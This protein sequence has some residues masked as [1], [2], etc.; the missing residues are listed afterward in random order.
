MVARAV[1]DVVLAIV[2]L[3]VFGL[4]ALAGVPAMG[5]HSVGMAGKF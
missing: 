2:F 5:L 1:P 4:G 3:R